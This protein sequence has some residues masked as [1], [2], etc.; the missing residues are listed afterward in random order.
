MKSTYVKHHFSS[1]LVFIKV[2]VTYQHFKVLIPP[3]KDC[4][5]IEKGVH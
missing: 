5:Q 2:L 4:V 1:P 3:T